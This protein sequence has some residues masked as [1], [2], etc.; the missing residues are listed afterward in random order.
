MKVFRFCILFLLF[1][2]TLFADVK[3][4]VP[5]SFISGEAL[6]FSVQ[7]S[8]S[9]IK[10]PDLSQIDGIPT[11]NMGSYSSI[12]SVNGKVSKTITK[13]YA[14]YANRDVNFPA[15][16][17]V[18]NGKEYTTKAKK[19]FLKQV[20]KT[21]SDLYDLEIQ[22][23]KN[24]I[25]LGEKFE[26]ILKFKFKEESELLEPSLIK[27]KLNNFWLTQVENYSKKYK[28]NDFI[29]LEL[30]FLL[31]PLKSGLQKIQPFMIQAKK[32][33]YGNFS[34]FSNTAKL[35]KIYS[36]SLN[37]KAKPLPQNVNLIGSFDISSSVNKTKVKKGEAVSF[38]IKITGQGNFD[39]IEDFKLDLPN[40]TIYEN[41]GKVKDKVYT[42]VF[43][44]I[45][46]KD[47]TIP[48]FELKYFDKNLNQVVTKYSKEHS[49]R[50]EKTSSVLSHSS[51]ELEKLQK[52]VKKEIVEK[53]IYKSSLL[54]NILYFILGGILTVLIFFI[55]FQVKKKKKEKS[56]QSLDIVKQIKKAK[57]KEELLKKLVP[58]IG[59]NFK[60]DKAI[61][62]IEKTTEL[63]KD[64]E[65]ILKLIKML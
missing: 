32:I 30:K 56:F 18:I 43:S 65:E 33:D 51:S 45:A 10:I 22:A 52:T 26:L 53:V 36:N 5:D 50:V 8:G 25:Y 41:K 37:I 13:K 60:L 39:D 54:N 62:N 48:K 7:I 42:K 11:Q 44:I 2:K 12:N 57:T 14:L 6:I 1:I 16:K 61:L 38:K 28:E 64:K 47:F 49:I 19:V 3:V 35:I 15:L 4:Q 63:Q 40:V 21:K 27:P 29:V 17:F 24:E 46:N 31:S 9:D 59:N 20:S 55:Y 58:Y 23:N 34:F